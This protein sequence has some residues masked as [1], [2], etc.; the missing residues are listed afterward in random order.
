MLGI[1]Y[2]YGET[3]NIIQMIE[4]TDTYTL[5]HTNVYEFIQNEN[6]LFCID[7]WV[8]SWSKDILFNYRDKWCRLPYYRFDLK[9]IDFDTDSNGH[10]LYQE[11]NYYIRYNYELCYMDILLNKEYVCYDVKTNEKY[12]VYFDSWLPNNF[13]FTLV[14]LH[15]LYVYSA[16]LDDNLML[17]DFEV[18]YHSISSVKECYYNIEYSLRHDLQLADYK[19][20]PLKIDYRD[21]RRYT[22]S[23][24]ICLTNMFIDTDDRY[25]IRRLKFESYLYCCLR[26]H[27]IPKDAVDLWK[28]L[29]TNLTYI[30]YKRNGIP[31]IIKSYWLDDVNICKK[32]TYDKRV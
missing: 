3:N 32:H 17:K 29:G 25:K 10:I 24:L 6:M 5:L 14:D 21:V 2:F 7:K 22:Y 13:E 8:Y 23:Q 12:K 26:E 1:P 30:K 19:V 4:H 27:L 15:N 9:S 11:G 18:G 28:Q 20:P 16:F 31:L